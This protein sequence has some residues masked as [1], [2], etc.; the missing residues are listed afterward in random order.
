M[1]D[2]NE[3]ELREELLHEEPDEKQEVAPKKNTKQALL[4]QIYKISERDGLPLNY[5]NSKLKRMSKSQLGRVL[6]ELIE[7]GMKRKMAEQVGCD[8]H[9]DDRTIA[10]GALRMLHDVVTVGVEKGGNMLLEPR[11]YKIEGFSDSLK[12]PQVS[13]VIDSCLA[14][15]AEEN[16][17]L[18]EYIQSPYARL[19]IAWCGSLAFCIRK[20]TQQNIKYNATTMESKPIR[21]PPA[22]GRGDSRRAPPRKIDPDPPSNKEVKAV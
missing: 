11:G 22:M 18:L 16:T 15:I 21:R 4:D 13:S 14:E 10:L 3:E 6:A 7:E 19:G 17:E 8:K 5:T 20:K 2:I 9:A 12:E 1:S